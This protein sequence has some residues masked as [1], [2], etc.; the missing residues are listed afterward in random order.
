MID[1]DNL[2]AGQV[3]RKLQLKEFVLIKNEKNNYELW[4][5]DISLIGQINTEGTEITLNGWAACNHRFTAYRTHSKAT[6]QNRSHSFN[7][8][9]NGS[10]L[11]LLQVAIEIGAKHGLMSVKGVFYEHKAIRQETIT[12]ICDLWSDGII[13][14]FYLDFTVFWSGDNYQ[15]HHCSLCCKHFEN[16]SKAA[17]NIWNEIEQIFQSF[18]LLFGDTPIVTDQGANTQADPMKSW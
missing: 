17:I 16:E 13:Q 10:L 4:Q 9:E 15:L 8:L 3:Q 7:T 5:H 11:D 1:P 14:R 18:E 6:G 2:Q 12:A